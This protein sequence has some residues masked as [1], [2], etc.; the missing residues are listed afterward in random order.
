MMTKFILELNSDELCKLKAHSKAINAYCGRKY[1][2]RVNA[3]NLLMSTLENN[4]TPY[5]D[6]PEGIIYQKEYKRL[7]KLTKKTKS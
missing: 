2:W 3:F 7:K 6:E 1:N 5:S 4:D